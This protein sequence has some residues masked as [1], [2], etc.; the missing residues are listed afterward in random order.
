VVRDPVVVAR[1]H[2]VPVGALVADLAT[3]EIALRIVGISASRPVL[4]IAVALAVLA[5]D[6]D[7]ETL[8]ERH[9]YRA[10]EAA[11]V[12]VADL[13]LA[14]RLEI[15]RRKRGGDVDRAAGRVAAEQRSL[16]AAKHFDA[17]DVGKIGLTLRQAWNVH[18][19]DIGRDRRIVGGAGILV[20]LATQR[21]ENEAGHR[22]PPGLDREAGRDALEV[23]RI[24]DLRGLDR[25]G[26]ERSHCNRGRLEILCGPAR[27]DNDVLN[28]G[29]D[30]CATAAFGA[31]GAVSTDWAGGGGGSTGGLDCCPKAAIADS[32]E[33]V[34]SSMCAAMELRL[35]CTLPQ[36]VGHPFLTTDSGW[37]AAL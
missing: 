23:G 19:I 31:R 20:L 24:L 36:Q 12:I 8:S 32:S 3:D 17:L 37:K 29:D 9:I 28:D 18:A 16:G 15:V 26:I 13:G 22:G 6:A 11:I 10:G 35:I 14:D 21:H 27:G 33:V 2:H 34:A 30:S 7:C 1:K 4:H 25:L 5:V